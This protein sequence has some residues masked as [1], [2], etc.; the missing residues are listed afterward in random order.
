MDG[1]AHPARTGLWILY[2]PCLLDADFLRL[3][4][5]A[6]QP[7]QRKFGRQRGA[8]SAEDPCRNPEEAGPAEFPIDVDPARTP[9]LLVVYEDGKAQSRRTALGM[10]REDHWALV[11]PTEA[12]PTR[13]G[14]GTCVPRF[15]VAWSLADVLHCPTGVVFRGYWT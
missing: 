5:L 3:F 9:S 7:A 15:P 10:H 8:E 14:K 4:F 13:K 2:V 6:E 1:F 11:P 12:G